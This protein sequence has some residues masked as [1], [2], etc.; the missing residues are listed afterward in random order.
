MVLEPGEMFL[1]PANVPHSP[2]RA[3]GSWTLVIERKRRP[4]EVDRWVWFCEKCDSKL[5]EAA[6]R[7]GAGPNDNANSSVE[8]TNTRLR[9]DLTLSTCKRC[10]DILT[11]ED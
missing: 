11:V 7:S 3:E 8:E 10:G 9:I 4:D 6:P 2:R 5:Y 1:L